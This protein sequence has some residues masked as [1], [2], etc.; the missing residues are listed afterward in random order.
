MKDEKLKDLTVN[1]KALGDL[2]ADA[3]TTDD[4][5]PADKILKNMSDKSKK[6]GELI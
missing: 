1:E 4:D 3:Y 2:V 6:K 5:I